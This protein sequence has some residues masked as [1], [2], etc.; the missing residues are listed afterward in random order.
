VRFLAFVVRL[1]RT[2]NSEFLVV[3][4]LNYLEKIMRTKK[5]NII[6]IISIQIKQDQNINMEKIVT[7]L[8]ARDAYTIDILT[9]AA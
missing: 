3:H 6:S 8:F 2:A 9:L 4:G 1:G 7:T 5:Q